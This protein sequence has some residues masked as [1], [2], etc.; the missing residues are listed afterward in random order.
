MAEPPQGF[1][2]VYPGQARDQLQ[3]WE[4]SASDTALRN[5]FLEALSAI[6]AHRKTD[7]LTWGERAFDLQHAGLAVCDGFHKRIHVRYAVDE[8]RRIVYVGKFQL[9]P[10]HPLSPPS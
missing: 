3:E 10:G 5:A 4:R 6:Q 7:P 2:V 9:L 8:A 1:R